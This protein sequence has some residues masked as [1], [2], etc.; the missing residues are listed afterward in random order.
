LQTSCVQRAPPPVA[1]MEIE[2]TSKLRSLTCVVVC[3]ASSSE[4][5]NIF[6]PEIRSKEN[7]ELVRSWKSPVRG[8]A[9]RSRPLTVSGT[10]LLVLV[11]CVTMSAFFLFFLPRVS[12]TPTKLNETYIQFLA[13]QNS[14]YS[15]VYTWWWCM[16]VPS[17]PIQP[18]SSWEL[19]RRLASRLRWILGNPSHP[20]GS[21]SVLH[22]VHCKLQ[23]RRNFL[24]RLVLVTLRCLLQGKLHQRTDDAC[25]LTVNRQHCTVSLPQYIITVFS[26]GDVAKED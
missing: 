1:T 22:H 2:L 16:Q 12:F 11:D 14:L 20:S 10:A 24:H 4:T 7:S 25:S 21:L 5:V 19:D 17:S 8:T 6:W 18:G 15:G 9:R 3:H 26:I 23:R 13:P